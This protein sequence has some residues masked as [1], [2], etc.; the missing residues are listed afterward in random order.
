MSK[1]RI[2]ALL[3]IAGALLANIAL[4]GLGEVFNYPDILQS[5]PELI[6]LA[7]VT[8]ESEIILL[9]TIL[10][11][12]AALL[13]PIA[14]M[15]DRLGGKRSL[16][17]SAWVGIA[18]AAV[19]FIGLSRWLFIVP[20]LAAPAD[21]ETFELSHKVLGTLVGETLG[22][23]LTGIWTVLIL[24]RLGRLLAGKWFTG[25]GYSAAALILLGV[26]I[27][28]GVPLVDFANFVGYVL[29]SIWLI[30]FGVILWRSGEDLRA[31][32]V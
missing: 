14:I 28:L 8:R 20:S 27:P 13:A 26:L 19:Q 17:T 7:F 21:I 15:V 11:V 30:A 4:A 18:A 22:Y 3:M 9:F 6:M 32:A 1:N 16:H 29:W 12:S 10:A 2:T 23:A 24:R 5:P 25:L 31:I